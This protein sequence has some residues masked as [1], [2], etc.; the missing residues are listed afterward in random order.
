MKNG[1]RM[2]QDMIDKRLQEIE[3]LRKYQ[4]WY[5]I[6]QSKIRKMWDK[7]SHLLQANGFKQP[8]WQ[9]DK[10]NWFNPIFYW[11]RGEKWEAPEYFEVHIRA[12]HK[13]SSF[14][15]L[16]N[17]YDIVLNRIQREL[18]KIKEEFPGLSYNFNPYSFKRGEKEDCK[19]KY[20]DIILIFKDL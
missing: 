3:D 8:D 6:Q 5:N 18:D 1:Y 11:E 4:E 7:L 20:V 19:E 2:A 12:V 15:R 17:W 16:N 10:G 14:G 13:I 9:M